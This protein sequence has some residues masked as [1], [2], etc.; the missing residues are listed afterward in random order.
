MTKEQATL[1]WEAVAHAWRAAS[2]LAAETGAHAQRM[3]DTPAGARFLH[4]LANEVLRFDTDAGVARSVGRLSSDLESGELDAPVP[5]RDRAVLALGAGLAP[6]FPGAACR[7]GRRIAWRYVGHLL[8]AA[9]GLEALLSTLERA[10][11]I[12]PVVGRVHSR[13]LGDRH[14]DLQLA[15]VERLVGEW[16]ARAVAL[17]LA[18]V[19]RLGDGGLGSA[20]RERLIDGLVHRLGPLAKLARSNETEL[21]FEVDQH[22]DL[23]LTASTVLRLLEDPDNIALRTAVTLPLNYSDSFSLMQQLVAGAQERRA[24]GGAPL[25]LRFAHADE[26][27]EERDTAE[28]NRWSARAHTEPAVVFANLTRCLEWLLEPHRVEGLRVV[29]ASERPHDHAFAWR[30]ARQRRVLRAV[31]H[32]LRM[33]VAP[34][35]ADV[36]K[37]VV[38]GVRLRVPVVSDR[39]DARA[40][41]YVVR[42]VRQWGEAAHLDVSAPAAEV[43][44][45]ELT[46]AGPRRVTVADPFSAEGREFF[47]GVEER[48]RSP[49]PSSVGAPPASLDDRVSS[50]TQAATEWAQRRDSTRAT[51]LRAVAESLA[52]SRESLVV[53]AMTESALTVTDAE[54]QVTQAIYAAMGSAGAAESLSAVRN[55]TFTPVTLTLVLVSR[56]SPILE[57]ASVIL[58]ALAAGSAVII[59]PAPE[60]V[61]SIGVLV[62]AIVDA[63]VPADLL[64]LLEPSESGEVRRVL[65]DE[66]VGRVVHSGSRHVVK[67]LRHDFAD[68]RLS[69]MT[70]GRNAVIVSESVDV[71]QAVADTIV[72]A[73]AQAGQAQGSVGTVILVGEHERFVSLL[74]DAVASL[75]VGPVAELDTEVGGLVRP[76]SGAMLECLTTL[77]EGERWL[78][79]P[80]RLD[81]EG[82]LWSPGLVDGVEP[83]SVR[84]A[85]ERRAPLLSIIRVPSFDDAV[86]VQNAPGFGFVASLQSG[87]PVE[88]AHWLDSAQ[89]GSLVV[90]SPT[91][92]AGALHHAVAGWRRSSVGLHR[93][94]AG[95]LFVESFGEWMPESPVADESVTLEGMS[96]PVAALIAATQPALSFD[97]FDWVRSA[98]RDDE[99][100]W[101]EIFAGDRE[102]SATS[103]ETA[104]LRHVPVATMVRLT[105][106]GSFPQL[107]RVLAAAVRVHAPVAVSSARPLPESLIGFFRSSDS[108]VAEV[109]VEAESRWLA[110]AHRGEIVT[111]RVRLIG[112]DGGALRR[113]LSRHAGVAVVTSPVSASG[114]AELAN[115][116]AEQLVRVP[117]P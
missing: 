42:R 67:A 109:V 117:T 35:L 6:F 5:W 95:R 91:A 114:R 97:E 62:A 76:A 68:A 103:G 82:R 56:S 3:A 10:G 9:E 116:V 61:H 39:G 71:E 8:A 31:E 14:A 88:V 13:A 34:A 78:V 69:S 43:P 66:R 15:D 110:R 51:V 22:R 38:G 40:A 107:V 79:A 80:R 57:P 87:D 1:D 89:A 100:A 106:E 50:A 32:E 102:L 52:Y 81:V 23:A 104:V 7:L 12:R 46:P 75:R 44:E 2:T 86:A 58:G 29:I 19:A 53:E 60:N 111:E 11:G 47:D 59:K 45:R 37:R 63:G 84:H 83:G 36:M 92:R 16:S 64:V 72:S 4:V 25:T 98:A 27:R 85:V 21:V 113:V 18:A 77:G 99:G 112:D 17:S 49:S 26:L 48:L 33:S 20:A 73:F 41:D 65:D 54:S 74:T 115:F 96:E 90:N 55:A 94:P 108:P 24:R 70:A 101:R 93:A 28:T 30:L 105:E